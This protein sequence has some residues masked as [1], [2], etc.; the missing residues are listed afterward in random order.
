M[1][2]RLITWTDLKWNCEYRGAWPIDEKGLKV[3]DRDP[4]DD[5]YMPCL[6]LKHPLFVVNAKYPKCESEKCPVWNKLE[7]P[8]AK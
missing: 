7:R 2:S 5:C 6:S 1:T 4:G 8:G 3:Y